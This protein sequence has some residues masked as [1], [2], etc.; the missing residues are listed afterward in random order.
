MEIVIAAVDAGFLTEPRDEFAF[1]QDL[2]THQV[3]TS[4]CFDCLFACVTLQHV[5]RGFCGLGRNKGIPGFS[6]GG[7]ACA[8]FNCHLHAC[9]LQSLAGKQTNCSDVIFDAQSV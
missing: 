7:L 4:V 9:V 2:T 6:G 5:H 3:S 8:P 1:Q